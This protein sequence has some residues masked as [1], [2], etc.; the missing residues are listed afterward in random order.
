[1]QKTTAEVSGLLT[2][3]PAAAWA[4]VSKKQIDL[5]VASGRFPAP[6]YVGKQS[7][8]WLQKHLDQWADDQR[9]SAPRKVKKPA[10]KISDR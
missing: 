10:L 8:R 9:G 2:K 7:P 3:E 1:M 5:L 4:K 6:I